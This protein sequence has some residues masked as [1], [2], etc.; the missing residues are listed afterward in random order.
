D[1]D[2]LLAT[3]HQGTG[4]GPQPAQPVAARVPETAAPIVVQGMVRTHLAVGVHLEAGLLDAAPGA[5]VDPGVAAVSGDLPP[6]VVGVVVRPE[7]H[8]GGEGDVPYSPDTVLVLPDDG[9]RGID[10]DGGHHLG[11][12]HPGPHLP[13]RTKEP[14]GGGELVPPVVEDQDAPTVLHL[15]ELPLPTAGRH[16][17]AP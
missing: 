14:E 6:L 4:A 15:L 2:A 5:A 9:A 13:D 3:P 12:A 7:V 10:L 8:V 11:G 16:L 17:P 1:I